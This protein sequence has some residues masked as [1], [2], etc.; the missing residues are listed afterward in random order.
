MTPIWWTAFARRRVG[1]CR[2]HRALP[3]A[4]ASS[5]P[6]DRRQSCR[7]R[8]SHT[9]HMAGRGA[10]C[11]TI[12]RSIVAQDVAVS[13]PRQSARS[14]V[15]RERRRAP[16]NASMIVSTGPAGGS[17]PNLGPIG[18][19]PCRRRASGRAPRAAPRVADE[20]ATSRC[21]RDLEGLSA[22]D[23]TDR[24]YHRR[25]PTGSSAPRRAHLR[26]LLSAEMG[27]E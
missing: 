4:H 6:D 7:R 8:R 13:H 17:P 2:A 3:T 16:S 15:G 21:L 11:R 5:R 1:L 14:T 12:R 20:S 27:A 18:R 23:V 10:W 26:Q 9:G 19:R 22:D 25:E 24:R